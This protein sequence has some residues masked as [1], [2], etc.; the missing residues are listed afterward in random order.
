[1]REKRLMFKDPSPGMRR[2]ARVG[3]FTGVIFLFL[4]LFDDLLSHIPG[5]L[6]DGGFGSGLVGLALPI[7]AIA[8]SFVALMSI[9]AVYLYGERDGK[10]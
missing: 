3:I 4:V 9:I 5:I 6:N 8:V 7:A 2:A 10:W 1:M